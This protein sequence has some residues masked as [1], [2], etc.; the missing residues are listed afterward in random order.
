L[1]TEPLELP[2]NGALAQSVSASASH[3][4]GRPFESDRPHQNS[5]SKLVCSYC[6]KA[7]LY[8]AGGRG[9]CRQ[10]YQQA[11]AAI[12]LYGAQKAALNFIKADKHLR[13]ISA[14]RDGGSWPA[15]KDRRIGDLSTRLGP[16]PNRRKYDKETRPNPNSRPRFMQGLA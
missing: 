16:K 10:H 13:A 15:K 7:A 12:K 6:D 11:V 3:A 8:K 4:E 5:P 1:R 9:Y 14:V 2:V